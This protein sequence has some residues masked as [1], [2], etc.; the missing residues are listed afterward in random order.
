MRCVKLTAACPNECSKAIYNMHFEP[1][2]GYVC[3]C[4]PVFLPVKEDEKLSSFALC[5]DIAPKV[6]KHWTVLHLERYSQVV[7]RRRPKFVSG[8][9]SY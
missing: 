3:A 1:G 2:L 9:A 7:T 4:V 6:K 5:Y 8:E